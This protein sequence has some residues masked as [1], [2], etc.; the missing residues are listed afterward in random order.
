MHLEHHRAGM[1]LPKVTLISCAQVV[2]E[3]RRSRVLLKAT[4]D[5]DKMRSRSCFDRVGAR[6]AILFRVDTSL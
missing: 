1:V 2:D 3:W 6:V 5:R 4:L